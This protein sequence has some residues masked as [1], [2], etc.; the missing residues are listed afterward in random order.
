MEFKQEFTAVCFGSLKTAM[1]EVLYLA[2][3]A[4]IQG[5]SQRVAS[6]HGILFSLTSTTVI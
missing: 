4:W 1:S 2:T 3:N 5:E 6:I